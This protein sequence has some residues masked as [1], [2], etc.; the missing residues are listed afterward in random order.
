MNFDQILSAVGGFGKYQKI[1]YI[2]ICLPQILLA[3]H[4]MVSIFT[5]STPPH[6]CRDSSISVA[7]NQSHFLGTLSLNFSL[8]DSSCFSSDD[9]LESNR[10]E[11]VPCSQGWV[12]SKETFQSTTVTEWDLV[13]N[14]AGL[15]SLGSSIYMF[16]LL[17]GS[18]L[19]GAMA[20]RYGRRFIL[21]LSIALQTGF[22]VAVAFAPNFS[23]YVILRFLVGTTVSGV[24]INA[25]VL[26]TEWTC[27][28]RRMLAGIFTDYAFGLGYMLLAGIAYLIRDWRKLQLAISAPGFL[29]IFYIWV[30][31]QSARWLLANDRMEEAI[32]LLRKA[33][34]VN[35]RV[36]PP[37]VQVE[38]CQILDGGKRSY[39]A[40]DLVRTPQMRK[41]TII[42][43]YIW[44][45][46]V[47]VYYGLSLGVS[48]L[49]TNLYLTQF[50]FGLIE[51]P[52]RSL[53]LLVL[54]FSRRLSQSG[55]LAVGGLA[56]LLMLAVPADHPNVLTGLAMVGKFGI[57]A[58]F[59][60]IYV[61]TAEIFPTVLRQ[62]GIG[63]S[64]MFARIGGVLAP[65]INMLHDHSL[66]TP[67]VIFGISPLLG[68]ILGLALPETADRPLPDTVE[69]AENW[70]MRSPP[71]KDNPEMSEDT[72]QSANSKEQQELRRLASQA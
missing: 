20:D 39:S 68:A 18:V 21:L 46:N 67:L 26:G 1:L 17:V 45:V 50:V 29:L 31:P 58:S 51:I 60:V 53:V 59:A 12:Y 6:H 4:M 8:S 40:M 57:T 61:Y 62:T 47:L 5:G 16:G 42:L 25:F 37:A 27:T 64:C 15:N 13:C 65:I 38:K 11:R 55:F 2:W 52:A 22:G 28:K 71:N 44:F 33:A 69:D 72:S 63:V 48:K 49:G 10:T 41:R 36:L 23:V 14:K 43:F 24:I 70:D 30:L 35:G 66:T 19:F 7:G 56:C 32:A 3:F 54:P 34:L 9:L